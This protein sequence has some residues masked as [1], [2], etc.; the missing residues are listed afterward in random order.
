ML[1]FLMLEVLMA[2]SLVA[3][4]LLPLLS[5]Q[6]I[7]LRDIEALNDKTIATQQLLNM[8]EMLLVMPADIALSRWNQ[9]NQ[10]V[11]PQGQGSVTQANNT[12]LLSWHF[13]GAVQTETLR[14]LS[15]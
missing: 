14:V 15:R 5:Y 3:L 7:L 4:I 1:G 9:R 12:I 13:Q 8:S 10:I 11:L 2:I 6:I